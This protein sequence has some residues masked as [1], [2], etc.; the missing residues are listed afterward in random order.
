MSMVS[1]QEVVLREPRRT[2]TA[3]LLTLKLELVS[4]FLCEGAGKGFNLDRRHIWS[5]QR[6]VR[7]QYEIIA[8]PS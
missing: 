1:K 2:L 6:S 5:K 4:Q 8:F 7:H 3:C